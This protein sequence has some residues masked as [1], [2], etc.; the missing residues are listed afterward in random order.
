MALFTHCTSSLSAAFSATMT[1]LV[2]PILAEISP[3]QCGPKRQTH[4]FLVHMS[5]GISPRLLAVND[6]TCTVHT[7]LKRPFGWYKWCH[8]TAY[9]S[10]DMPFAIWL[11][12][13]GLIVECE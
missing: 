2:P 3:L 5:M 1:P 11:A 13:G 6:T 9:I 8:C 7:R 10:G 4:F 12:N